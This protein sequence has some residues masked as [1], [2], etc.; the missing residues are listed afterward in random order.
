[1][2][3]FGAGAKA[4][5][6]YNNLL[7]YAAEEI[8]DLERKL[9]SAKFY[10]ECSRKENLNLLY[11]LKVTTGQFTV[12]ELKILRRLCHPDRHDGKRVSTDMTTKLNKLI[13]AD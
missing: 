12:N 6:K 10:L 7:T 13:K 5:V 4:E 2:F 1:M 9:Q 8:L 11:K 3:G